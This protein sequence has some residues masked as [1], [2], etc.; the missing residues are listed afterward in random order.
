[1]GFRSRATPSLLTWVLTNNSTSHYKKSTYLKM[2]EHKI[3]GSDVQLNNVDYLFACFFMRIQM[4]CW[5]GNA[6]QLCHYCRCLFLCVCAGFWRLLLLQASCCGKEGFVWPQGD[7]HQTAKRTTGKTCVSFTQL[8]I[9]NFGNENGQKTNWITHK[10]CLYL[11]R[12]GASIDNSLSS[13]VSFSLH[14]SPSIYPPEPI[15]GTMTQTQ[16][17]GLHFVHGLDFSSAFVK[18]FFVSRY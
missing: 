1:M 4:P 7:A 10:V 11:R 16:Q 9:M 8:L 5:A 12:R 15:R 2:L 6:I 17:L 14:T 13:S 3:G 18:S